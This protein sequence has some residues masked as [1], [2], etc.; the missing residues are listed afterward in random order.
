MPRFR[1]F[2]QDGSDLP[3]FVTS[4]LAWAPG[5]VVLYNP[6]MRFRVTAVISGDEYDSDE[7]DALLEVEPVSCG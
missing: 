3:D 7:H 5:D 2:L 1:V 4:E 6:A